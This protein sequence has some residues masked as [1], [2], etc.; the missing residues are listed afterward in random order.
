MPA[1]APRAPPEAPRPPTD[2]Q[3]VAHAVRVAAKDPELVAR[4]DAPRFQ[5][6][7]G[8]AGSI[9]NLWSM[10]KGDDPGDPATA[11]RVCTGI[12]D[13][14]ALVLEA[15]RARGELP[16]VAAAEVIER[17]N[18]PGRDGALTPYHSAV[19]LTLESGAEV[20]IDWHATLDVD[21]PDIATP[22]T[23]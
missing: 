8:F 10:L 4:V 16:G 7:G 19:K 6:F 1:P 12:A 22:D 15:A 3:I 5:R 21:R 17:H 9:R 13:R 2:A 18:V 20:V 23:F 14:G 11:R